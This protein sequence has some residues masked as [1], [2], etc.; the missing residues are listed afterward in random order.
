MIESIGRS[1]RADSVAN[2]AGNN[3]ET[4]TRCS[5]TCVWAARSARV[6]RGVHRAASSRRLSC[7]EEDQATPLPQAGAIR[8]HV[9][10]SAVTYYAQNPVVTH[11]R[12]RQV[13]D[14]K[15]PRAPPPKKE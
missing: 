10:S 11:R 3:V 6:E 15:Y 12:S 2:A 4:S 14:R 8:V 5:H 13:G 7:N 9:H 1:G